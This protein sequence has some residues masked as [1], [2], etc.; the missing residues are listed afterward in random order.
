MTARARALS[1]QVSAVA[2]V[3]RPSS[4]HL[5]IYDKASGRR[6]Q[7]DHFDEWAPWNKRPADLPPREWLYARHYLAGVLSMT[8]A[9]PGVGKSTLAIVEAICMA[10][11]R[12]LLGSPIAKPLNVFYW[13][14][15]ETFVE[16]KRRVFAACQ[17][18]GIDPRELQC[19]LRIASG[20]TSPI[21][22]ATGSGGEPEFDTGAIGRLR[23][24]IFEWGI[25]VWIVD[26]FIASHRVNENNNMEIDAVAKC[27]SR[28]ADRTGAAIELIHHTRKTQG[29][30]GAAD[31]RGASALIAAA[32]SVRV[33]N[34][35]TETEAARA[36][37]K[38]HR[39][40]F[41]T[42]LGKANYAAAGMS[43]W[44]QLIPVDLPNGDS[45]ATVAPWAFPATF[46]GVEAVHRERV[47]TK[48][49][50]QEYR[51]DPR[52]DQWVGRLIA[53]VIGL[54]LKTDKA[55]ISAM[56]KAWLADGTLAEFELMDATRHRRKYIKP[57]DW[58]GASVAV[59]D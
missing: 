45:V 31:S 34:P 20:L 2:V 50:E 26:P 58:K 8:V 25:N 53:N 57:G 49:A 5:Q 51:A 54:D 42:D 40:F 19:R 37:L 41:R 55:R 30:T 24:R 44:F 38:D 35:M 18:F 17:H 48:A 39:G 28:T 59:S 22:I 47:C 15:E 10:T 32:R 52:S 36:S 33:L 23:D 13:N 3:A 46:D 12:N 11:G 16:I 56:I 21:V 1:P 7:A 43:K 9:P 14:G 4:N 6:R 27:W 29:D